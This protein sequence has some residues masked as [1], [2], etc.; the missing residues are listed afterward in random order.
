MNKSPGIDGLTPEFYKHF[1][2]T[3]QTPLC[4]MINETYTTGHLPESSKLAVVSLIY[5]NG[6]PQLLKNYRPISLMNYDYKV[7]AFVLA[8]RFQNVVNKV[9]S[10][11]QSAYIK[12]RFLGNNVRL[13]CDIIDYCDKYEE[14]GVLLSLDFEKA[15]DTVEWD[16]V[17]ECLTKFN[18]GT[19][20]INWI[21]ILYTEPQLV[22][23]NNGYFSKK[24][25]LSRGLR[26]GCPISALLFILVVE[27]LAVKIKNN[28][29]IKGFQF[30]THEVKISQ[31]ADDMMLILS[32]INSVTHG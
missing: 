24:I 7:L 12:D 10:N 13:V 20:F 23:K 11:D 22:I 6:D 28:K 9:I 21:K 32:D 26:Q 1:W 31:Y 19:N 15:F 18:F 5:K 14:A 17:F 25:K 30:N 27:V 3:L 2:N 8:Q 29:S 4:D 16:F